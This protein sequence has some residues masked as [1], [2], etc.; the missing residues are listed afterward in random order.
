MKLPPKFLDLDFLG[1]GENSVTLHLGF[2]FCLLPMGIIHCK[3]YREIFKIT[4]F[5]PVLIRRPTLYYA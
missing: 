3:K 5:I 2:T 1:A 4:S